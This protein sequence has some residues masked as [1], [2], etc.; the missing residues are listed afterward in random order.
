MGDKKLGSRPVGLQPILHF[1]NSNT[2]SSAAFYPKQVFI[3]IFIHIG[4]GVYAA[5]ESASTGA[6]KATVFFCKVH[7]I[8]RIKEQILSEIM[9]PSRQIFVGCGILD[10]G[11]CIEVVQILL[12][13][14]CGI[15]KVHRH[16]AVVGIIRNGNH[17]NFPICTLHYAVA[18]RNVSILFR[19]STKEHIVFAVIGII[20]YLRCPDILP[21]GSAYLAGLTVYIVLNIKSIAN[22]LPI[23]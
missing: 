11:S 21:Y 2:V 17:N 14:A 5:F 7:I 16:K 1:Y 15:L 22:R 4:M 13:A 20:Y 19:R 10:A 23:H 6:D 3:A 8:F 18:C 12:T 9:R